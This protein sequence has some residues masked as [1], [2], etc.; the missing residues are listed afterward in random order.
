[1]VL[2]RTLA[3]LVLSWPLMAVAQ[4]IEPRLYSNAPVGVNFALAGYVYTQGGLALDPALPVADT[5][6][7]TSSALVAYARALDVGGLSGKVDVVVPYGWL[8]GTA[9]Y[10]G[11]PI[12]RVV[13]GFGDPGS[14]SR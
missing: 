1:M 9:T 5:Q 14:A 8:S 7:R 3:V 4:D 11:D 13:D 10:N 2:S 6:L 12:E